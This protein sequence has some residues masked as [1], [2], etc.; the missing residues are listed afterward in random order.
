MVQVFWTPGHTPDSIVLWYPYANRLFVGDLFYQFQDIMLNY[1][2][3]DIKE[4]EK[5]VRRIL[6]FVN[7]HEA[8]I[9]YSS[10]KSEKDNQ[11]LPIFKQYH[12]FLL[13]VIAGTHVGNDL[14]RKDVFICCERSN[15]LQQNH[16]EFNSG[17]PNQQFTK[18]DAAIYSR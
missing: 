10:A 3:T 6:Q 18:H 8:P 1:E 11:C 4:Y 9:R 12:R 16:G 7:E 5:S 14:R 17:E 13:A 15:F 2:C